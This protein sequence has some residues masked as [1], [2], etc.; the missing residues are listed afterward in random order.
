LTQSFLCWE[1]EVGEE[2]D[3]KRPSM[4]PKVSS[5]V[6]SQVLVL[7]EDRMRSKDITMRDVKIPEGAI[8][9]LAVG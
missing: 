4:E 8:A 5:L 1:Q 2:D 7:D 6:R 9:E 3:Q